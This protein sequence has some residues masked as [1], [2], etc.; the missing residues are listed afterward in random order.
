MSN[1]STVVE[2]SEII[3]MFNSLLRSI[4]HIRKLI[5]SDTLDDDDLYDAEE[6][7]NDYVMLLSR[8]RQ[9]YSEIPEK[10]ELAPD[11]IKRISAI[12]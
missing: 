10:G 1:D 11:V 4:E 5:D 6:E 9:R 12:C 2:W 7:L 8:L 3:V